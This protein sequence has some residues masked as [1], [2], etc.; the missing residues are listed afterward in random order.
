MPDAGL[1]YEFMVNLKMHKEDVRSPDL[2]HKNPK[3]SNQSLT[4]GNGT[5]SAGAMG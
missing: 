2:S 3:A 4:P 1:A 5:Q